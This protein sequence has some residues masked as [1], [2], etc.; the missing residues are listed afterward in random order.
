M[1]VNNNKNNDRRE[2]S[3]NATQNRIRLEETWWH[4]W[5]LSMWL[6]WL[7]LSQFL[8]SV[9]FS[10]IILIQ[11][12]ACRCR[13]TSTCLE[14]DHSVPSEASSLVIHTRQAIA[15]QPTGWDW[16][17]PLNSIRNT[18]FQRRCASIQLHGNNW[19]VEREIVGYSKNIRTDGNC[20]IRSILLCRCSVMCT[21]CS[22]HRLQLHA[23]HI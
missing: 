13:T 20:I 17:L 8:V 4:K 14:I 16:L 12:A 11:R 19:M 21:H 7:A 6:I 5:L 9:I 1:Y 23:D 3:E 18:L 15:R 10:A 2:R 22:E